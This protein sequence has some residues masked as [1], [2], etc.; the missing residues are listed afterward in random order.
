MPDTGTVVLDASAMVDLLLD[1]DGAHLIREAL[2]GRSLTAP[3]HFDVE[4]ASAIGRLNR[5]GDLSDE[6]SAARI[7]RLE[8]APIHRAMLTPL[9]SGAWARRHDTR[10]TDALYL[11]LASSLDTVVVTTDRRLARAHPALA[12]VPT[13]GE[14]D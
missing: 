6:A 11:E 7:D 1:V 14:P 8:S 13:D 2:E 3:A 12:H 4:V 9:L 10:L 5:G